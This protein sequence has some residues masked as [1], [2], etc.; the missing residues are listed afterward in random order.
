M[1]VDVLNRLDPLTTSF[2]QLKDAVGSTVGKQLPS[3]K[4][5]REGNA[6]TLF[7]FEHGD[8]TL[9]VFSNGFYIY[10]CFGKET[11]SAVDRCKRIIYEYQD[12][13]IRKI[14]EPEFRDGPCLIPLLLSGDERVAHNLDSYEW[15]WHEFSLSKNAENW[16]SEASS[17][18]PEDFY[19]DKERLDD[20]QD[21]LDR[22]TKRQRQVIQLYYVE[23]MTF[24]QIAKLLNLSYSTVH[25]ALVSGM[26]RLRSSL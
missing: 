11:V 13:E 14:E 10:E 22:L 3:A 7:V 18:G 23:D 15:Y 1:S 4:A 2:K 16:A 20:V 12:G 25:E 8:F 5:L 6:E 9:T 26:E 24:K 21:A 19:L 17:A